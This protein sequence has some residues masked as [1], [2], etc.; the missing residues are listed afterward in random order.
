MPSAVLESALRVSVSGHQLESGDK[1]M[2]R[3]TERLPLARNALGDSQASDHTTA[4][5]LGLGSVRHFLAIRTLDESDG[6]DFATGLTDHAGGFVT[7]DDL[8][9]L[10]RLAWV[11]GWGLLAPRTLTV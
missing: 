9:L 10:S 1:I 11:D 5:E 4:G 2:V 3:I 6:E 7:V 8:H